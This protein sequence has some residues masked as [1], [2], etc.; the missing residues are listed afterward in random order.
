M[1]QGGA[2]GKVQNAEDF[3]HL[4]AAITGEELAA[5]KELAWQSEHISGESVAALF[6]KE[7]GLTALTGAMPF[8]ETTKRTSLAATDNPLQLKSESL[9]QFLAQ[10]RAL[11]RSY[12]Q[13][14]AD[15]Q[16][17]SVGDYSAAHITQITSGVSGMEAANFALFLATVILTQSNK[18]TLLIDADPQNQFLFPLLTLPEDPK[19]LTEN[20]QKPSTFRADLNKCILPLTKNLFYLN[21]QAAS[22]RPFDEQEI[23]RLC[24][25]LDAD[26]E[27]LV[28]YTGFFR[29]AWLTANAQTNYAVCP[30]NYKGELN[31]LLR[32]ARGFHTV[33]L[34]KGSEQYLPCLSE[35]FSEKLPLDAWLAT[36]PALATL[37]DFIVRT[38]QATR[39]VIGG[40]ENLPGYLYC[41][42]GFDLYARYASLEATEAERALNAL[43]KK[44]RAYY[45]KSAFFSVRSILNRI[46]NLP[47][48]A[49]TTILETGNEPQLVSLLSS[50]ELRAAAVFPAGILPAILA[51]NTRISACTAHGFVRF[52][53]MAARG[54]FSR[55]MTAPRYRLQK[56]NA[57]AA[58]MEQV[59][60]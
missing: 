45:P 52:K 33:L 9:G 32:H 11:F 39:L 56:P 15:S 20:L 3:S 2:G 54:G 13:T 51:Q 48:R 42:T 49:A 41:H 6:S 27:N 1:A 18:K 17:T 34:K 7:I 23:A 16:Y 31:A 25:F 47:Q 8:L 4:F 55:V 30:D 36:P 60:A 24:G 53:A 59:Q 38:H 14:A 21:L 5:L 26:F 37:K 58:V 10:Q 57:L 12:R 40:R 46:R 35:P 50:P 28:F 29:S 19:L 44:L 43:Q 22:L